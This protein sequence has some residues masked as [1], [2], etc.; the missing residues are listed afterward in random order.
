MQAL[1]PIPDSILA[2]LGLAMVCGV[3]IVF[4]I[5]WGDWTARRQEQAR[6]SATVLPP[7]IVH[8]QQRLDEIERRLQALEQR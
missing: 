7:Q 4:G 3:G 8:L 2:L 6:A 1:P 5:A